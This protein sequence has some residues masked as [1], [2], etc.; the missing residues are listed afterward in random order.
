MSRRSFVIR[1]RMCWRSTSSFVSPG[2]AR[3][4]AAAQ[5]RHR[6][7]PAAQPRQQVVELRELD[8][9]LALAL[10]AR[11]ARRCP[12]S[13]R[14]DRSPSRRSRSS[15]DRS[16]PGE[17][18]WS[19]I[20][21]SARFA[22]ITSW[23]S[24][25]LPL[26]TNVAGIRARRGSARPARQVRLRPSRR[27]R[28][29]RPGPP[30]PSPDPRPTSTAR[31]RTRGRHV[32]DSG[33]SST[34]RRSVRLGSAVAGGHH[35]SPAPGRPNSRSTSFST[36]LDLGPRVPVADD[37]AARQPVA[38]AGKSL[39]RVPGMTMARG[40][41][42]PRCSTGSESGDVD[43]RH[44]GGQDDAGADHRLAADPHAFDD[45]A[46]RADEGTVLH[47][48]RRGL[49]R[50]QHAA[51][52]DAAGQV[53]VRARSARTSRP[54]PTCPPWCPVRPRR[55]CSRSS[56]S[57]PRRATGTRRT[58]PWRAAPPAPRTRRS[59]YFSGSLSWY[60]NGPDLDRLHRADAEVQQDRLLGPL[61]HD[62]AAVRG[63]RR[64]GPHPGRASR[65]PVLDGRG[66]DVPVLGREARLD[67]RGQVRVGSTL[68]HA[69]RVRTARSRG[70][71]RRARNPSRSPPSPSERSP[72]PPVRRTTRGRRPCLRAPGARAPTRGR[73]GR[74]APGPTGT[75]PPPPRDLHARA[76]G[77]GPGSARAS[78][79][80]RRR[81]S[82]TW[83][84]SLQA[85]TGRALDE[86]LEA[87]APVEGRSAFI[88]AISRASPAMN[89]SDN[90]SCSSACSGC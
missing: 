12:G 25:S 77:T 55:R 64:R 36:S 88:A 85:A 31:S 59:P 22:W 49:E 90:P 21:A 9:R 17:S 66:V 18:S 58:A 81:C 32:A 50:L 7:A 27:A 33:D 5:P 35:A 68:R 42:Y 39:V 72:L 87:S 29:A 3:A 84:S 79:A 86:L 51:D 44:A 45:H 78:S 30:P 40:G 37:Q 53:H 89:P 10:N 74:R 80:Y 2:P 67:P 16:C 23:S 57:A 20:T 69:P 11:A 15:S 6:L 56:A 28:R 13:A 48:H 34:S 19:R 71:R 41:T 26:P 47:D 61:V 8:L 52:A 24:S 73:A 60:S 62:P 75:C 38:P 54:S 1:R 46:A 43:H 65:S 70:S 14:S 76:L 4:D 82:C 63:A 83:T